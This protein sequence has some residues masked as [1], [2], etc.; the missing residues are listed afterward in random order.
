M[1]MSF[2]LLVFTIL[3]VALFA[4]FFLNYSSNLPETNNITQQITYVDFNIT[5]SITWSDSRSEEYLFDLKNPI[6]V[7]LIF[8][9]S[10]AGDISQIKVE[11]DFVS[12][13]IQS[14]PI[15]LLHSKD[16]APGIKTLK[17][18]T[19]KGDLN[20]T[21]LAFTFP[22]SEY[23]KLSN[24]DKNLLIQTVIEVSSRGEQNYEITESL[25]VMQNYANELN[26]ETITTQELTENKNMNKLNFAAS[27]SKLLRAVNALKK[28]VTEKKIEWF[29][30][31]D[32]KASLT[33]TSINYFDDQNDISL[34]F[35]LNQPTLEE[36][37]LVFTNDKNIQW[38]IP[39]NLSLIR[40]QNVTIPLKL[41]SYAKSKGIQPGD[42]AYLELSRHTT[43]VEALPKLKMLYNGEL[44]ERIELTIT[45]MEELRKSPWPNMF[46]FGLTNLNP[47]K[48]ISTPITYPLNLRTV[49]QVEHSMQIPQIELGQ[50]VEGIDVSIGSF[51][52]ISEKYIDEE[53]YQLVINSDYTKIMASNGWT[54]SDLP[55]V[56]DFNI[57]LKYFLSKT[58]T[59]IRIKINLNKS[60]VVL[61]SSK[62]IDAANYISNLKGWSKI[63][64]DDTN[65]DYP[66]TNKIDSSLTVAKEIKKQLKNKYNQGPFVFLQ[67]L[68]DANQIPIQEPLLLKSYRPDEGA[69]LDSYYYGDVDEDNY[70]EL[71]VARIPLISP[72]D[73]I[74]YFNNTPK[75]NSLKIAI[76]VYPD[77]MNGGINYLNEKIKSYKDSNKP[78]PKD[79]IEQKDYW[80][81]L[82]KTNKGIIGMEGMISPARIEKDF[83]LYSYDY[84]VITVGQNTQRTDLNVLIYINPSN[85]NEILNNNDIV[86]I[87]AHGFPQGFYDTWN[88]S[89]FTCPLLHLNENNRPFISGIACSTAKEIGKKLISEGAL[90]YNGNYYPAGWSPFSFFNLTQGQSVGESIRALESAHRIEHFYYSILYG[91]PSMIFP[92]NN[93][94]VTTQNGKLFFKIT[95]INFIKSDSLDEL[96]KYNRLTLE[97]SPDDLIYISQV[98]HMN[99][100]QISGIYTGP[101]FE[102]INFAIMKVKDKNMPIKIIRESNWDP[103][104]TFDFD[105]SADVKKFLYDNNA[106][107]QGFSVE[108]VTKFKN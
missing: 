90:I 98:E 47:T 82:V 61:A 78:I 89:S 12:Q 36:F 108:F 68:G 14:D 84:K 54:E 20:K 7:F 10:V 5:K 39:K 9:K 28:S 45:G 57:S 88:S 99:Y 38:Y 1:K 53:P 63:I 67:I 44:V 73:I 64:F 15:L 19:P 75:F 48:T 4:I 43:N 79:L 18:I 6:I 17:L 81:S 33:S 59:P 101:K 35:V 80:D 100:A 30:Y 42:K 96:E 3:F 103:K 2:K 60:G 27:I 76:A 94:L 104:Y 91:D 97:K 32:V 46:E 55:K 105:F 62:L 34:N 51:D 41:L 8:P 106:I 86:E 74:N 83:K 40:G 25:N 69:V 13:V 26:N 31:Y 24:S 95:D 102:D 85:L 93:S 87:Y 56:I 92:V 52:L 107:K 70:P 23:V 72:Q 58:P 50:N 16:L 22:Y 77:D 65:E 37:S 21:S 49:A 11:G 71:A 29:E 66:I